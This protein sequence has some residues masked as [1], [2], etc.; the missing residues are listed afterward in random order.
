MTETFA[1]FSKIKEI[2][3][4]VVKENND[5]I[6]AQKNLQIVKEEMDKLTEKLELIINAFEINISFLHKI[7]KK[8]DIKPIMK[9]FYVKHHKK[10]LSKMVE[11]SKKLSQEKC[12]IIID[13]NRNFYET[14]RQ[15]SAENDF[16]E[17]YV[18][19]ITQTKKIRCQ[20]KIHDAPKEWRQIL[21][22]DEE[23][24]NK[25]IYVQ[26]ISEFFLEHYEEYLRFMIWKSATEG[27]NEYRGYFIKNNNGREGNYY[28]RA[29][30]PYHDLQDSNMFFKSYLDIDRVLKKL[31]N[32]NYY[33]KFNSW[34]GEFIIKW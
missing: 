11:I 23:I 17:S 27:K 10:F 13:F 4:K 18:A 26:S 31:E 33:A 14:A 28:L 3:E 16:F 9:E 2:T 24:N 7:P 34:T 21:P 22:V 6:C 19:E 20:F 30:R 25:K 8:V 5:V 29:L 15:F 32:E 12:I 1:S